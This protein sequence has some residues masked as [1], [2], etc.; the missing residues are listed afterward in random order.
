MSFYLLIFLYRMTI[1]TGTSQ[2]GSICTTIFDFRRQKFVWAMAGPV[3]KDQLSAICVCKF[4]YRKRRASCCN[5]KTMC[6]RKCRIILMDTWYSYSGI[7]LDG[8]NLREFM[9][10]K[11]IQTWFLS[12]CRHIPHP[13][14]SIHFFPPVTETVPLRRHPAKSF[15]LPSWIA[16]YNSRISKL[17][18]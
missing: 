17:I 16:L 6:G 11:L 3:Q 12:P 13:Q 1:S 15:Q 2:A 9:R 7:C 14:I 4:D 18:T 10:S 5:W 8:R